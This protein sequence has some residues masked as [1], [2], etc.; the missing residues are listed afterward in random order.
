MTLL[1]AGVCSLLTVPHENINMTSDYNIRDCL[2]FVL[3]LCSG[4]LEPKNCLSASC[5]SDVS[6]CRRGCRTGA[7]AANA[8]STPG[9]NEAS[10]GQIM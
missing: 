9:L 10:R 5:A 2:G 4:K 8:T 7:K 6:S 3:Q 1:A